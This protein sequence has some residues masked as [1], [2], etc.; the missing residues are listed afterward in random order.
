LSRLQPAS[1]RPSRSRSRFASIRLVHRFVAAH[2][3]SVGLLSRRGS[4]ETARRLVVFR[5]GST[6]PNDDHVRSRTQLP[7]RSPGLGLT[8]AHSRGSPAGT[9]LA[10]RSV[11][12]KE[13]EMMEAADQPQRTAE[14]LGACK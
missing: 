12:E 7:P 10:L 8:R 1:S 2:D 11:G 6:G 5:A 14:A 3:G 13:Q 4:A 9:G